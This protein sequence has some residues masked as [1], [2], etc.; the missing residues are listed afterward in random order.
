[1]AFD[2][3]WIVARAPPGNSSELD[4]ATS[5][6]QNGLSV[7]ELLCPDLMSATLWSQKQGQ[8]VLLFLTHGL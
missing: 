7:F 6:N 3:Y 1:M 5:L 4:E 2:W 8:Q